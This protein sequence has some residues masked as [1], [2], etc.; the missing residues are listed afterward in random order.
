LE[1]RSILRLN[2]LSLQSGYMKQDFKK[3]K[4]NNGV[5]LPIA[6]I[7]IEGQQHKCGELQ[8]VLKSLNPTPLVVGVDETWERNQ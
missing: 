8:S 2:P 7:N 5:T 3:R 6:L 1:N 4:L